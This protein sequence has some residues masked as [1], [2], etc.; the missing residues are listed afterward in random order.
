M[1]KTKRT[2]VKRYHKGDGVVPGTSR[3]TGEGQG[4]AKKLEKRGEHL[5]CI[6]FLNFNMQYTNE[7]YFHIST[8]CTKWTVFLIA[9]VVKRLPK[10]KELKNHIDSG[11]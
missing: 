4:D 3:D 11:Q 9:K 2:P 1:A 6:S 10:K 7:S 5:Q 8:A